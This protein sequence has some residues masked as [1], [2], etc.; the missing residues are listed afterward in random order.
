ME[1]LAA[2]IEKM[3]GKT[4]A[5]Q[6]R[7]NAKMESSQEEFKATRNRHQ[8]KMAAC[9]AE[10]RAWRNKTMARQEIMEACLKSKEPTSVEIRV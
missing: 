10:M 1:H 6:E 4:G 8:E 2:A 5:N 9:L 3:D 7:M